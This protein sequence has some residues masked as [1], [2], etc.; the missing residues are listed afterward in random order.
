MQASKTPRQGNS[1][2]LHLPQ[3]LSE[4]ALAELPRIHQT[5]LGEVDV[6][7]V[8]RIGG[9][10]AADSRSD[11]DRVGFEDDSVIDDLVDSEGNKVVVLDDGTLV[12]G[13]PVEYLR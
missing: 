7:H 12:G 10:G 11:H 2:S 6:L 3:A 9:G 5:L 1:L 4:T 13:A 8:G